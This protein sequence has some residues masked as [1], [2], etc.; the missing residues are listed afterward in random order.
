MTL[1]DQDGDAADAV[2]QLTVQVTAADGTVVLAAGTPTDRTGTGQYT[3]DL[4]SA[5]TAQLNLLTAT[6]TDAGAGRTVTTMHEIVGGFLF[7][8]ADA[9]A[10]NDGLLAD[11][12]KYPDALVLAT[13][14]EVEEEAEWIC[15]VA[16]VP[17]YQRVIID[18]EATIDIVV[19]Y[20]KIRTVRSVRTYP[21]TGGTQYIAFTPAQLAGLAIGDDGTLTRTDFA[22]FDEGRSNIVVE[23]EHGWDSPPADLKRAALTRLRSRLNFDKGAVND[24]AT[25][26]TAENGQTYKLSTADEYSTGIPEVDAAY[27]RYSLRRQDGGAYPTSRQLNFDP[28]RYSIFHGGVR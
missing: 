25:S 26:F 1:A 19:P 6:W 24:R 5:Q 7:S 10:S 21:V 3:V 17:R 9:R 15:D 8:L 28:Q 12:A 22:A 18:G 27:T 23:L 11:K 2:G 20:N 16:F 4:T 13:R 14:Q